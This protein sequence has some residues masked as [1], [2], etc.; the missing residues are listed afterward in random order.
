MCGN[1]KVAEVWGGVRE[2]V[3]VWGRMQEGVEEW[4]GS[5]NFRKRLGVEKWEGRGGPGGSAEGRGRV[6]GLRRCGGSAEG[7]VGEGMRRAQ[8]T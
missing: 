1:G 3:K 7:R 6:G 2:G 8:K 4:E 5:G